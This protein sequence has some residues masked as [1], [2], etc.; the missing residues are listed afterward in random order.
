MVK[1]DSLGIPI[2]NS[3]GEL[4]EEIL[5]QA[6]Q[7]YGFMCDYY[8]G[9]GTHGLGPYST[10]V[11]YSRL[12]MPVEDGF[13]FQIYVGEPRL[14]AIHNSSSKKRIVPECKLF[15]VKT[16]RN[17]TPK[18]Y[19]CINV[20][21]ALKTGNISEEIVKQLVQ[22]ESF[23]NS[24][25]TYFMGKAGMYHIQVVPPPQHDVYHIKRS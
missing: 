7:A 11:R 6:S 13:E 2:I 19:S 1:I 24:E 17:L 21:E 15:D 20:F 8:W 12:I 22:K 3:L 9:R 16:Y 25:A 18:D 4:T 10:Q 23:K 14:W 5:S